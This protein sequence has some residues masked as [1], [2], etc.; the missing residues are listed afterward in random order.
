MHP[1]QNNRL[2][3]ISSRTH[4]FHLPFGKRHPEPCKPKRESPGFPVLKYPRLRAK[5]VLLTGMEIL[6]LGSVATL[7]GKQQNKK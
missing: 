4:P 1:L 2:L 7:T 5:G 3:I 6:P